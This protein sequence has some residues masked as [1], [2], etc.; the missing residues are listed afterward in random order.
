MAKKI[1]PATAEDTTRVPPAL[2]TS[3][4]CVTFPAGNTHTFENGITIEEGQTM[5][6]DMEGWPKHHD[7][8][9]LQRDGG[10]PFVR[11]C[12]IAPARSSNRDQ[13]CMVVLDSD[14][15]SL[16]DIPL[17]KYERIGVFTGIVPVGS[18]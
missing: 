18:A 14:G 1:V 4:N 16:V 7:L 6:F 12:E 15:D 13:W 17:G 8:V 5:V 2:V 10:S 9:L 3:K 11:C